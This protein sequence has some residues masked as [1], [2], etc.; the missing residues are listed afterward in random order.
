M[1]SLTPV[2][3]HLS[4]VKFFDTKLNAVNTVQHLGKITVIEAKAL[5]RDINPSNTFIN[6]STRVEEF[7]VNTQS[8]LELRP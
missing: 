8:L 7:E 1:S 6:K 2:K 4:T 3:V 5:V